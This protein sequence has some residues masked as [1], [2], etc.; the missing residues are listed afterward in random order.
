MRRFFLL[1][2]FLAVVLCCS[3]VFA[4]QLDWQ[5]K[6]HSF[7]NVHS[8]LIKDIAFSDKDKTENDILV[9]LFDEEFS[10]SYKKKFKEDWAVVKDFANADLVIETRV[11]GISDGSYVVPAYT[12]WEDRPR[13]RRD[14]DGREITYYVS[15][16]VYHP[17]EVVYVSSLKVRFDVYDA[18][19]NKVVFS[20]EDDRD[21]QHSN[22]GQQGMFRR[23]CNS[24]FGDFATKIRKDSGKD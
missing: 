4:K 13:T 7:S 19:T 2:A 17:E 24:F 10:E 12:S 8:I 16:P 21:R 15:V 3:P 1:V 23:I 20:R 18:K 14:R 5:D 11:L 22:R 6:A 9:R